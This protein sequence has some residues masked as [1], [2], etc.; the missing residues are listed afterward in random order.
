MGI[1]RDLIAPPMQRES[2][3]VLYLSGPMSNIAEHNF[4]AFIDAAHALRQKGHFVISAHEVPHD[5]NK[6]PGS[7]PWEEYLR[8]DLIAMLLHCN[9]IVLLPGWEQSSGA[10]LEAHVARRLRWKT[11]LYGGNGNI[12]E[13]SL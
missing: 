13:A 8:G 10:Q 4:P 12:V 1:L 3:E 11:Y 7:I 6:E 9:A 5:D 2:E